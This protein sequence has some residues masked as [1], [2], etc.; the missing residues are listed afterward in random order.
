MLGERLGH[1]RI[2]EKI[3]AGGM[4]E[5]YRA[6]DELLE[7][8]VAIKI[9]SS[10]VLADEEVRMRFRREALVLAKLNHPYIETIHEFGHQ[11]DID[12]LVMELIPGRPLSKLLKD[13]PLDEK[14]PLRLGAQFLKGLSAAHEQGVIHRDLKPANLFVTPDGR[15]KILD[16]GLAKLVHPQNAMEVTR[17]ITT[18][19]GTV[20][21]TVPYMSPEQLRGLSIDARSDIYAAGAVLHE[22]ATGRRAFP[23]TQG[24]ELM[25]AILYESA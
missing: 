7:R 6:Y 5:V 4:G 23:Q 21:G 15:V 19:T 24:A 3:G 2:I 12:F 13:G 14:E 9:L 1:Y 18:E 11:G 16:F 10:E 8:D 25:G 20:S 22:M 17:S